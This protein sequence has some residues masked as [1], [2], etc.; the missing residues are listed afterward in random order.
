[1][2]PPDAGEDGDDPVGEAD[3]P[4]EDPD[5]EPEEVRPCESGPEVPVVGLTLS[6]IAAALANPAPAS[7]RCSA[8]AASLAT[9]ASG[10]VSDGLAK[11]L[12][13][14]AALAALSSAFSAGADEPEPEPAADSAF[15]FDADLASGSVFPAAA[16][17]TPSTTVSADFGA[18]S[19]S[20]SAGFETD[21]PDA[22]DADACADADG[23]VVSVFVGLS[24]LVVLT[25]F[26]DGLVSDVELFGF[27]SRSGLDL[28]FGSDLPGLGV[29]P[30]TL[31][32][33]PPASSAS[34]VTGS[35]WLS[36]RPPVNVLAT[37]LS[38]TSGAWALIVGSSQS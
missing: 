14:P 17:L 23:C 4:V 35:A 29:G 33:T 36:T 26:S 34:C 21:G 12:A 22:G 18:V 37:T 2:N 27:F 7:S 25:G 24:G 3:D 19:T 11:L 13:D 20:V 10:F 38:A 8:A 16:G 5:D 1:L 6:A 15:P 30:S 32:V 9:E 28:D 31:G